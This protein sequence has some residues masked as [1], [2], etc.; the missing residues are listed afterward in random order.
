MNVSHKIYKETVKE[1]F[2]LDSKKHQNIF[3]NF[4]KNI[5]KNL[6]LAKR[7]ALIFWNF[8][9]EENIDLKKLKN[10]IDE[11]IIGK[12]GISQNK[13]NL[14]NLYEFKI[15]KIKY[16]RSWYKSMDLKAS[17][18]KI[19]IEENLVFA[20]ILIFEAA[21][22][23]FK[24]LLIQKLEQKLEYINRMKNLFLKYQNKIKSNDKL[25]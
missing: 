15:E 21:L 23:N 12:E 18:K 13:N 2:Y 8:E 16:L 14:M 3:P 19:D 1:V 5:Q 17:I 9:F 25:S 20:E 7:T 10:Q 11:K 4:S 24:D 22:K 6:K